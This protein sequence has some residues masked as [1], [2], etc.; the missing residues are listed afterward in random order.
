MKTHGGPNR[1]QGRKPISDTDQT[2]T[3]CMRMTETQRKKLENLGGAKW[4]RDRIT[5]AK[6]PK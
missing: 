5:R 4:V 6:E 3:F 2:I 1:N